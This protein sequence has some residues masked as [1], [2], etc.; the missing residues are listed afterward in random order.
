MLE[1]TNSLDGAHLQ[2]QQLFKPLWENLF[3]PYAN[4][5]ADQFAH[6]RSLISAFVIRYL[7][8]IIPTF[9]LSEISSL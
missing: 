5:D 4:K 2:R 3:L 8:S 6:S 7:D 9:S 1:D